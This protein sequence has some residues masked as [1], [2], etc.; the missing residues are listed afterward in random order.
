[1]VVLRRGSAVACHW[2]RN[3]EYEGRVGGSH[4]RGI[5]SAAI[6]QRTGVEWGGHRMKA[7]T[8]ALRIVIYEG[9]PAAAL[10]QPSRFE[11][12]RLLLERGYHVA[13]VR[14]DREDFDFNS[15]PLVLLGRFG[16]NQIRPDL[17]SDNG[18]HLR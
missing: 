11:I 13:C 10:D 16:G 6:G 5:V 7:T 1:M 4:R 2:D 15:D 18:H 9:A 8:T 3:L 17:N 12:M 14:S